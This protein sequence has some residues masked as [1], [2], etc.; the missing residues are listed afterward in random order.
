M[1]KE[2]YDGERL[3]QRQ[4]SLTPVSEKRAREFVKKYIADAKAE[5]QPPTLAGLER[6]SRAAD[7]GGRDRLRAAFH[8]KLG[9]DAPK[10]GRPRRL[11]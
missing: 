1:P 5:G 9:P 8:E 2:C 4:T 3:H 11:K 10:R 6:A 7:L